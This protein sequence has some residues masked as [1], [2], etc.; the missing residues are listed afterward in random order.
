MSSEAHSANKR[1]RSSPPRCC[2]IFLD[3]SG[4]G[5][6]PC[7]L[8]G[9]CFSGKGSHR[10]W[11]PAK[12]TVCSDLTHRVDHGDKSASTTLH[13]L[14]VKLRTSRA[15]A[16]GKK[17]W[18]ASPPP[19]DAGDFFTSEEDRKKYLTQATSS[20]KRQTG[21]STSA[22]SESRGGTSLS[23]PPAKTPRTTPT[24]FP[25]NLKEE[26]SRMLCSL[27]QDLWREVLLE[28]LD[29]SHLSSEELTPLPLDKAVLEDIVALTPPHLLRKAILLH[30][31]V[32]DA[33]QPATPREPG[34]ITPAQ[35]SPGGSPHLLPFRKDLDLSSESDNNDLD[36]KEQPHLWD[37]DQDSVLNL[38]HE[39][40]FLVVIQLFLACP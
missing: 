25:A 10:L 5:Y 31:G 26:V 12:C 28:K 39:V 13:K 18:E 2:R 6:H 23:P 27:H 19:F 29:A 21:R 38:S 32:K 30:L 11:D 22:E 4:E 1:V 35:H 37:S 20:R 36:S 24:T 17:K 9:E 33:S 16:W 40:S 34:L 15:N 3:H 14:F 7:L 8:H